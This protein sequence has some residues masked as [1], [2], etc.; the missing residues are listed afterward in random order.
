MTIKIKLLHMKKLIFSGAARL[1]LLCMIPVSMIGQGNQSTGIP[2]RVK[3]CDTLW[4][5]GLD[6]SHV[7]VTDVEKIPR[8]LNYSKVYPAAWVEYLEKELS[9]YDD[10]RYELKNY[11]FV[12]VPDEVQRKTR[13]V[14][15][16]FIIG[17]D[18]AFPADTV[19][20]AVS[21]YQLTREKGMGLIV[22]AENFNKP[23][24]VSTAW[25]TFF[26]IHTRE[27]VWAVRVTGHAH[28]MGYTAHWGAG[29]E[30]GV[31]DFLKSYF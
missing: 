29:L 14:V 27:I 26:D 15:P 2:Q 3:N 5:Y 25:V 24:E 30:D 4:Y 20:K 22:I 6:I 23:D 17:K 1:M 31:R 12:Y 7:R 19:Q 11:G 8:S 18:Y 9:P 21:S 16:D 28:H 10:V 13:F